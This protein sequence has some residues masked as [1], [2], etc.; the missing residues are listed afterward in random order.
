M[1]NNEKREENLDKKSL[2]KDKVINEGRRIVVN[3]NVEKEKEN[4]IEKRKLRKIDVM[5][6][7]KEKEISE[8]QIVELKI[9]KVIKKEGKIS[10]GIID[11]RIKKMREVFELEG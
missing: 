6:I 2:D 7:M 3:I 5:K 10:I 9:E 8:K 1:R 4:L 11:E